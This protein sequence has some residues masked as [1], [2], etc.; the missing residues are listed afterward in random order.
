MGVLLTDGLWFC[1]DLA[2]YIDEGV[3]WLETNL[4]R[5]LMGNHEALL[6]RYRD[7]LLWARKNPAPDIELGA[8]ATELQAAINWWDAL[9]DRLIGFHGWHV[10]WRGR[11]HTA[12]P[13]FSTAARALQLHRDEADRLAWPES[14]PIAL[15]VFDQSF[16]GA[17]KGFR[18]TE[19]NP[20]LTWGD[21]LN[22]QSDGQELEGFDE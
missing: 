3:N 8:S 12:G 19:P 17:Y 16:D 10:A 21:L 7:L 22:P 9:G 18:H 4:V 13:G 2:L 6:G 5:P 1:E 20:P 15:Y 11:L 14:S